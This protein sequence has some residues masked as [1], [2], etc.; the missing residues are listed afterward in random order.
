MIEFLFWPGCPSHERALAMLRKAMDERGVDPSQLTI[1]E[2]DTDDQG[3]ERDF[4]GSPTIRVNGADIQDPGDQP[5]GLTCRSY[6]RRDGRISP[7]PDPADIADA[8]AAAYGGASD[9]AG[10]AR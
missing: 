7:L 9:G 1:V 5:R 10:Q 4:P 3:E 2:I 8:L 6:R